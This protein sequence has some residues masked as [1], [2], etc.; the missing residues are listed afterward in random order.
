[1]IFKEL[2]KIVTQAKTDGRPSPYIRNLLKEYLQVYVLFFIYTSRTYQKNL[3]FTGGTCLRHFYDLERLSE[4]LDF[5][6]LNDFEVRQLGQNLETFFKTR[7]HYAE[8]SS[9]L[10]QAEKQILLKFPALRNLGL[11]RSSESNLLYIKIDLSKNISSHFDLE[12]SSKSLFGFNFVARHYDLPS[13]MAGKINAILTRTRLQGADDRQT[14]KGRDYFDLLWFLKKGI[15][16]N[17]PRLCDLLGR[18]LSLNQVVN[19]I[20]EKVQTM[21]DKYKSDFIADLQPLL[22]NPEI[23]K[24]YVENFRQEYERN[25]IITAPL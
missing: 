15:K 13:L 5:D 21:L 3:I 19:L 25:R 8:V 11:A 20:D 22:V 12:T 16:P 17:L 14:I 23:V 4:D 7:Y 10:K 24:M 18:K 1:M 2:E 9:S 6:C